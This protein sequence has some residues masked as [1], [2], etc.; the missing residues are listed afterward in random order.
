MTIFN[1]LKA[2]IAILAI[3]Y[4]NCVAAVTFAQVEQ[5]FDTLQT[6]YNSSIGLWVPSTGWWNSA[7]CLTMLAGLAAIDSRIKTRTGHFWEEVFTNAA[8]HNSLMTA[9]IGPTWRS[10][11]VAANAWSSSHGL[12]HIGNGQHVGFI[13]DFYDDEGW[14]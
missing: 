5:T 14:W 10:N 3:G 4:T 2:C 11:F 1:H 6:W 13:N 12:S 9:A 8:Q 7:N